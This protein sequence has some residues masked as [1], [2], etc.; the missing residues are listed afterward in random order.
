MVV[1][2]HFAEHRI[3]VCSDAPTFDIAPP[4]TLV[5]FCNEEAHKAGGQD[6]LEFV[7]NLE[8]V[9]VHAFKK[10]N[11]LISWL[12]KREVQRPCY[13][14]ATWREA[15]PCIQAF[16][17]EPHLIWVLRMVITCESTKQVNHVQR[18]VRNQTALQFPIDVAEGN[19]ALHILKYAIARDAK[20]RPRQQHPMSSLA[21]K[22]AQMPQPVKI[23]QG[24]SF[25]SMLPS[26]PSLPLD[27][28]RNFDCD[29]SK[30]FE[31][32]ADTSASSHHR[33]SDS[34]L[35]SSSWIGA[36]CQWSSASS[37]VTSFM[38]PAKI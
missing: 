36:S 11:K 23:S 20:E 34:S 10:A 6:Q 9:K 27:T 32:S 19:D 26:L 33:S 13:V 35:Q 8:N 14:L 3:S 22:I 16:E 12:Q 31:S 38:E 28:T 24:P 1:P 5:I 30:M 4:K 17:I 2:A 29:W 21:L 25:V 37:T 18:W 15:R 7:D